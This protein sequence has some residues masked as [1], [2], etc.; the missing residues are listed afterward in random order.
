MMCS[1]QLLEAALEQAGL[2][3]EI[4]AREVKVTKGSSTGEGV[5]VLISEDAAQ[6]CIRHF[7]GLKWAKAQQPI[8]ARYCAARGRSLMERKK[9]CQQ[10]PPGAEATNEALQSTPQEKALK[11][12]PGAELDST[13]R[14]SLQQEVLTPKLKTSSL[15]AFSTSPCKTKKLWADYDTDDEFESEC[16][17]SYAPPEFQHSRACAPTTGKL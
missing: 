2:E 3:S 13:Q 16:R 6:R 9:R 7:Q 15:S 17:A 8:T 5:V 11:L 14:R 10:Q 4:L 1:E 12:Q